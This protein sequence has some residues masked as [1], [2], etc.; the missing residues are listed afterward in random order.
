[1]PILIDENDVVEVA[2]KIE[3]LKKSQQQQIPPGYVPIEMSTK[4]KLGVP[5]VLYARNFSTEDVVNLSMATDI[6][7]PERLIATLRSLLLDKTVRVEDWPDKSV[8]E[9]LVKI[10]ANFFTPMLT[11]IAFPWNEEDIDWLENHD[12][13]DKIEAL[14]EGKWNPIVDI[15]LRKINIKDI[16][17]DVRDY[18]IIK[19]KKGVPLEAK[20]STYPRI[21]DTLIIKKL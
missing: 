16:D 7:L 21:G 14:R 13:K 18:I 2:Q 11:S 12:Q 19:R 3:T 4:G 6:L 10:Y 1:M 5:E 9:L 15:D 8:I 20:F 17:P